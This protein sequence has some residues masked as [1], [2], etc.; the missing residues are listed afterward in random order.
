MKY[1]IAAI[2]YAAMFT[3]ASLYLWITASIKSIFKTDYYKEKIK[4]WWNYTP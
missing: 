1:K 4:T 2:I 3:V